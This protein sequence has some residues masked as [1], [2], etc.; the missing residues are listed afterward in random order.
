MRKRLKLELSVT[1][2][3]ILERAAQERG[4]EVGELLRRALNTYLYLVGESFND[5]TV[6]VIAS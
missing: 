3:A 2:D 5:G 6:R 1:A 4:I